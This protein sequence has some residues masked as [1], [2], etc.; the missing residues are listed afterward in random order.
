MK[1][2]FFSNFFLT[3]FL[4]G[5]SKK[6][7]SPFLSQVAPSVPCE[8]FDVPNYIFH[9]SVTIGVHHIHL[10]QFLT[11][12]EQSSR[13]LYIFQRKKFKKIFF[14]LL[15]SLAAGLLSLRLRVMMSIGV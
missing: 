10:Q 13:P 8:I 1:Q 5:I 7:K 12:F 15:H 9:F 14:K 4:G 3:D 6:S 2:V 11:F